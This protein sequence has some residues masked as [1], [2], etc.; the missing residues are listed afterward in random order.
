MTVGDGNDDQYSTR[1]SGADGTDNQYGDNDGVSTVRRD[2]D[3]MMA[4]T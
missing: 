1:I 4:M 2:G 3:E